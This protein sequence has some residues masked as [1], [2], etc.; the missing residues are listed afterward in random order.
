MAN[1]RISADTIARLRSAWP[2]LLIAVADGEP[3]GDSIRKYGFSPDMVRAYR[4]LFPDAS[5]QWELAREQSADALAD[6]ALAT[7]NNPALDPAHARLYVDTLKW[8]AAKRNPRA[9][10]DKAMLDVNVKTVD[11]TAIIVAANAR[12]AAANQG[13]VIEHD[14]SAVPQLADLL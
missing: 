13:R 1:Q 11:L 6:K 14:A 8:A 10:S 4:A 12:L 7:A 5:R 9:Y 3:I 2:D